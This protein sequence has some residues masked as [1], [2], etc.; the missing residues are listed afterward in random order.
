MKRVL[1]TAG[2]VLACLG[3]FMI[4]SGIYREKIIDH[5]TYINANVT[6]VTCTYE[7]IHDYY[8]TINVM[9]P[10]QD[11]IRQGI[12]HNSYNDIPHNMTSYLIEVNNHGHI[13]NITQGTVNFLYGI[14]TVLIILGIM[15]VIYVY[16]ETH[17]L[18]YVPI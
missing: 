8:C 4:F 3:A 6:N 14:G 15:T 7:G 13:I 16:A 17:K 9:Y 18:G 1:I 12:C 2:A 5:S 10:W 11:L